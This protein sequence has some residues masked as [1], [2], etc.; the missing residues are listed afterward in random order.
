MWLEQL[1]A[2][3]NVINSYFEKKR[4]LEPGIAQ[5]ASSTL[6]MVIVHR[7]SVKLLKL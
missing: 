7:F 4:K 1:I 5:S 6:F 3:F 2:I